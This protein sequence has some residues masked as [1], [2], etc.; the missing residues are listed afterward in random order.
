MI[1]ISFCRPVRNGAIAIKTADLGAWLYDLAQVNF[2]DIKFK[3]GLL[4][5]RILYQ[6]RPCYV[7]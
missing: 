2:S 4:E 6:V 3:S 5:A 1:F 7:L